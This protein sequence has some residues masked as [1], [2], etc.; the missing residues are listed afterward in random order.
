MGSFLQKLLTNPED[1][2]FYTGNQKGAVSPNNQNPRTIPFGRDRFNDGLKDGSNQPYIY[3]NNKQKLV[4]ISGK[5]SAFYNDFTIRGG[6]L[7]PLKAAEDVLRLTRFFSDIKNPKGILFLAKQNLLSRIGTKT[8]ASKGIGYAGGGLNEG[9]YTPLSTIGQALVGFAGGHLNKQGLDP[10]GLFASANINKYQDIIAENQI[11]RGDNFDFSDNRLTSLY[12]YIITS[13]FAPGNSFN[14][15]KGYSLTP[16]SNILIEYG[17]GPGSVLGIGK[18]NIKYATKNDGANKSTVF[19]NKKDINSFVKNSF[20]PLTIDGT[21]PLAINLN[22]L[23][24]LFK[25]EPITGNI[26]YFPKSTFGKKQYDSDILLEYKG[27]PGS[28]DKV[29]GTTKIKYATDNS[30][31]KST[32][33]DNKNYINSFQQNAN[34]PIR[35]VQSQV[36]DGV[37]NNRLYYLLEKTPQS[38][39]YFRYF[40]KYDSSVLI[41]Y[42]KGSK[43]GF[44]GDPNNITKIKYATDNYGFKLTV[45]DS[46]NS[47]NL[48]NANGA[49]Y[50][51]WDY[52]LINSQLLNIDGDINE[53]FRTTMGVDSSGGASTFVAFSPDYKKYNI[54]DKL[55]LGNP[56]KRGRNRSSYTDG[57]NAGTPLDKVNA[58]YIYKTEVSTKKIELLYKK[59]GSYVDI[60]PFIISILNNDN[61]EKENPG[62]YRKNMHFRAFIDSFS[63]S[64][65][66]DWSPIEYMGRA[67]KL[68]KY[69]GFGRKISMAFT[70]VAQSREEIT[71]MYDK[72]NFLASSLAPEYLDS[73]TSGYMAG[74]IAYVTL[75]E[76]IYDQPGIITSLTFDI[77]E[78]S[79]WEI[80]IDDAGN[81]LD[82]NDVRQVP[83]MIK[84]TGFNFTPIH[85]FRPEKQTFLNDILGTDSIRLLGTGKQRYVD[86]RRPESTNYDEE[87]LE[88]YKSETEK[89][90]LRKLADV[91]RK[92]IQKQAENNAAVASF[93]P[94]PTFFQPTSF[95]GPQ[96]QLPVQ[97]LTQNNTLV[98]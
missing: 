50:K 81:R 41:E 38:F 74:N 85:K 71:V 95:I 16:S 37:N 5:N 20:S 21:S 44:G 6:I 68:Y 10:T 15:V 55:N 86:Q 84:V 54:E 61:Q 46:K 36:A 89:E 92:R 18:T 39:P 29:D 59:D 57:S 11:N 83:H 87:A 14:G 63:D 98:G 58:S 22:R 66:A 28:N 25:K 91:E 64:Y 42:P 76:Y 30:G 51:T 75:G 4:D 97:D 78:E 26:S 27:G 48:L 69:K 32:V 7:A 31:F 67:E 88:K 60:I 34:P 45:F 90:K 1:F 8:E 73:L 23:V 24:N 93:A 9:V 79:P 2:K 70:V 47:S 49:R 13:S 62:T 19:N 65:D 35:L 43:S 56:G 3:E 17:G 94:N 96:N 82:V 53:D 72:L 12:T 80:G 77:P 33:F 40:P 52:S